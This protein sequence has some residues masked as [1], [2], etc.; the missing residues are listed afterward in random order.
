[1]IISSALTYFT[2]DYITVEINKQIVSLQTVSKTIQNITTVSL[3]GGVKVFYSITSIS[4]KSK[5][6]GEIGI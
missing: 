1:M 4:K 6:N 2:M 3:V 5:S